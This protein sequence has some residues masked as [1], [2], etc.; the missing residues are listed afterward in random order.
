[1]KYTEKWQPVNEN[2]NC[3]ASDFDKRFPIDRS[4]EYKSFFKKYRTRFV[5]HPDCSPGYVRVSTISR[6]KMPHCYWNLY[7]KY[8]KSFLPIDLFKSTECMMSFEE[9]KK[10]FDYEIQ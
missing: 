5:Q 4:F 2:G 9:V 6:W 7:K 3:T 1:M 8:M 10:K